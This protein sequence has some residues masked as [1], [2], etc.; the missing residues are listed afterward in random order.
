[1]PGLLTLASP[2]WTHDWQMLFRYYSTQQRRAA[3][4]FVYLNLGYQLTSGLSDRN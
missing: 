1:M 2:P 4:T 3:G